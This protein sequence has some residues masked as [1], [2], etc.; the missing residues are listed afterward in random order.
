MES[1]I[2]WLSEFR[3]LSKLSPF[4]V[5]H[6]IVPL[7]A[8]PNHHPQKYSN[9]CTY[10]LFTQQMKIH[11]LFILFSRVFLL[12]FEQYPT[13]QWYCLFLNN[14]TL[15]Q[16]LKFYLNEWLLW[17]WITFENITIAISPT[18]LCRSKNHQKTFYLHHIDLI[19]GEL[20]V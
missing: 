8:T 15:C 18:H 11:F 1:V 16:Y 14:P 4:A 12:S 9:R 5:G 20:A 6:F 2:Q 17:V 3:D 13:T 10:F 7:V 19:M